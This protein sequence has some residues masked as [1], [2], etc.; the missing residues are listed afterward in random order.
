MHE[1]YMFN[2]KLTTI[3]EEGA[4][5]YKKGAT[6][7]VRRDIPT[8][9]NDFPKDGNHWLRIDDI[10]CIYIDMKN[11]TRLSASQKD[12]QTANAY[13][14]FTDTAVRILDHFGAA[15][16]DIRGD[17]AFGLF[18]KTDFYRGMCAAVTFLTFAAIDLQ[19]NATIDRKP[20]SCHIGADK[21][22]VLAKRIGIRSYGGLTDKQNEVW[23][24][25][26]VNMAAKLASIGGNN[27]FH[28]SERVHDKIKAEDCQGLL[29]DCG[30]KAGISSDASPAW[31][32]KTV[33]GSESHIFDFEKYYKLI[34]RSWCVDIHGADTM[35]AIMS[36]NAE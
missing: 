24:G 12:R 27:E 1:R 9:I 13:E 5:V 31:E 19:K 23:A 32:E 21:K 26:P 28:I 14:Y 20:L 7:Q 25:K 3:F 29:Q 6:I 17:G 11:S 33:S 4:A 34:P 18:N 8:D 16:I 36:H 15:Y 30:C 22:T 10:L 35:A 2:E